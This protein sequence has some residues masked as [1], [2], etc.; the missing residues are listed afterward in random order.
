MPSKKE[1]PDHPE[2]AFIPLLTVG[3]PAKM[4]MA[5]FLKKRPTGGAI[6]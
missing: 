2:G 4:V 1:S 5:I 6:V 3:I